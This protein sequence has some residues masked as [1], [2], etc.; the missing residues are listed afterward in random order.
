MTTPAAAAPT[1]LDGSP[2]VRMLK[3]S[4]NAARS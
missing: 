1:T 3:A 2:V 4:D